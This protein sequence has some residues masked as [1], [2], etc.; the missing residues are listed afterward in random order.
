MPKTELLSALQPAFAKISDMGIRY[1]ALPGHTTEPCDAMNTVLSEKWSEKR[2]IKIFSIGV[3]SVT[4][5]PED[6]ERLKNVQTFAN[7]T[8]AAAHLA[9][10]QAQAMR[11]AANNPNGAMNGFFGMGMAQNMG[12]NIQGLYN[13]GAQQQPQPTQPAPQVAPDVGGWDCSCGKKGNTGK[14]CAEC[15][16]PKPAETEGWKCA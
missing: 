2:G 1:S 12:G 7:P 11:D 15:G 9:G 10:A 8:F 13:M 6:E 3:N 14:F 5:S 4:A 16:Q